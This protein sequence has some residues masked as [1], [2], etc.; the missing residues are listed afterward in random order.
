M[1]M[2]QSALSPSSLGSWA[3]IMIFLFAVSGSPALG[4]GAFDCGSNGSDG[5]LSFAS[6]D[7]TPY[8]VDFD[9]TKFN[10]PLDADHDGVYHFTSITVPKNVTVRFPADKAGWSPLYF[11]SQGDVI[12]SGTLDLSGA[13]GHPASNTKAGTLS[14]PGAGG[15]PGGWG[16]IPALGIGRRAG[17]GLSGDNNYAGTHPGNNFISPLAGGGGGAGCWGNPAGGGGAGG[18]ALLLASNT[19]IVVSGSILVRGGNGGILNSGSYSDGFAGAGGSLRILAPVFSGTG[20][21][22]VNRGG[23]Y[24]DYNGYSAEAGW[25]RIE[26]TQDLFTGTINGGSTGR[27]RRVTLVPSAVYIAPAGG[28]PQLR[29]TRINDIDVPVSPTGSFAIPDV[30]LNSSSSVSFEVSGSNVPLGT[31][32]TI[33]LWNETNLMDQFQT[34]GLQ[35]TL[36]AS[37]ATATRV[38]PNGMTRGFVYA[39]FQQ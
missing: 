2:R 14:M 5:A 22:D 6:N 21:L 13:Q 15:L 17:F 18:G 38:I 12:V 27:V 7:G 3:F 30:V 26:S 24:Q 16:D 37:T 28:V 20:T 4:A 39:R 1:S 32:C 9:P 23:S 8:S 34:S 25:L 29:L 31:Q 35:G 33:V 11:L 36:N 10:P 19:S